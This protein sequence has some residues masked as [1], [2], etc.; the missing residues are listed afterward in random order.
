LW[1]DESQAGTGGCDALTDADPVTVLPD[2]REVLEQ[3]VRT[4]STP[5]RWRFAPRIILHAVEGMGVRKSAR[6]LGVWPK[7]ARYWRKRWR[8]AD[9]SALSANALPMRPRSAAP[10]TYTPEQICAV[11]AM[12]C[13]KP[14]ESERPISQWSQREI[15]D[16]AIRR[17][18][19]RI[20]RSAQWG[21]F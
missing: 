5:H 16:E 9:D 10:A 15:A 11:V 6:E 3:L 1:Q 18:L 4:H 19:V 14:S 8:D 13:E 12:T 2:Q 17:G 7:T 21:V 20:S